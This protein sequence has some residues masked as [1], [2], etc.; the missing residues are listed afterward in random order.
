MIVRHKAGVSRK[1]VRHAPSCRQSANERLGMAVKALTESNQKLVA[2]ETKNQDLRTMLDE[3]ECQ[4]R[5]LQ[6]A[7]SEVFE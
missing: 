5:R 3:K 7:K 1:R 2:T 4:I 6:E